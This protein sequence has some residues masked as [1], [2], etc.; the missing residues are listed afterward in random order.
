MGRDPLLPVVDNPIRA[1]YLNERN[2]IMMH[3][4]S[5][6]AR[7]LVTTWVAAAGSLMV[8]AEEIDAPAPPSKAAQTSPGDVREAATQHGANAKDPDHAGIWKEAM[9]PRGTMHGEFES[10]D[11]IGLTAGVK[12]KADCSLNWVDPD[13]HRLYCFSSATSLN[14]FLDEP[15]SYLARASESWKSLGAASP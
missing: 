11:P 10:N 1:V 3:H 5:R 2:H 14:F 8:A 6:S 9:P 15:R 12:I 7:V 4:A 13:T